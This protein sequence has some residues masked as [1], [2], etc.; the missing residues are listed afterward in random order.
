MVSHDAYLIS[1][2]LCFL[3]TALTEFRS[4]GLWMTHTCLNTCTYTVISTL[5][6]TCRHTYGWA[7]TQ[8]N[9]TSHR[10]E[11]TGTHRHRGSCV[12]INTHDLNLATHTHTHRHKETNCPDGIWLCDLR[13]VVWGSLLLNPLNALGIPPSSSLSLSLP[14][15]PPSVLLYGWMNTYH[16]ADKEPSTL[17]L[18]LSLRAMFTPSECSA[19]RRCFQRL[20]SLDAAEMSA[21]PRLHF[22]PQK[23]QTRT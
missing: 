3:L 11:L 13:S 2:S 12:Q 16:S 10:H 18:A 8:M 19:F 9:M 21:L 14:Y 7:Q 15:P 20:H 6:L 17:E 1:R 5:S 23:L 4:C 22:L